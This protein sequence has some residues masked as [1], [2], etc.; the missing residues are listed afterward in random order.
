MITTELPVTIQRALEACRTLPTMPSVAVRVLDLFRESD[1]S[2][3]DVVKAITNDPALTS[4]ILRV[5][6]S[7][8][9]GVRSQ[10]TTLNRAVSLLGINATL[11]ISLSFSLVRSLKESNSRMLFDHQGYWRRSVISATAA[12]AVASFNEDTKP[13]ELFL[14]GLLQ[15]IG[16]LVLNEA[17]TEIYGPIIASADGDHGALVEF[18]HMELQ[19]DHA[20]VGGWLLAKWGLPEIF[21]TATILSH[22]PQDIQPSDLFS[23][24]VAV[25]A[26]ITDIFTNPNTAAA[27]TAAST[28]AN[29]LLQISPEHFNA[30]LGEINVDLPRAT[31]ILNID[32]GDQNL[33]E[34][35][36][37]KARE[38][39]VK[40]NLQAQKQISQAKI[41][42]THDENT[43]LYNR[44]YL[45]EFLPQQFEL[46]KQNGQSLSLIFIDIDNF[47]SIND[48]YGHHAGDIALHSVAD[49]IRSVTRN[50]D[51]VARYG[52]DEFVVLLSGS[53]Q[54]TAAMVAER[55]RAG[56]ESQSYMVGLNIEVRITVSVGCAT[57]TS[58]K[59]FS[60]AEELL[61]T[62]DKCLYAAKTNGRNQVVI[63][64]SQPA[65]SL[66]ESS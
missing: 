33:M 45:N 53:S 39:L 44:A 54:Q 51:T 26:G 14:A 9:Y 66:I 12:R 48:Y 49:V 5:A 43:S 24:S 63:H 61:K 11:S 55:I 32:I 36:L 41:Q 38:L 2:I 40:L 42:A 7:P 17:I 60:S 65:A 59:S 30:L 16:I 1:I 25:G 19:T 57:M 31:E 27:T 46:C 35:L 20:E 21:R 22:T 13:E 4:K 3:S 52:G 64:N 6:N 37:D 62:A 15:D 29:S 58:S 34:R 47:K 50:I 23:K 28:L 18:E 56:I 8:L 10:V